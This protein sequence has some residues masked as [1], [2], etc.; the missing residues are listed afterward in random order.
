MGLIITPLLREPDY[1]SSR[2]V[3]D[4]VASFLEELCEESDKYGCPVYD[5]TSIAAHLLTYIDKYE[6][7]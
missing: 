2:S 1:V 5:Y 7:I 6:M 4:N 3:L